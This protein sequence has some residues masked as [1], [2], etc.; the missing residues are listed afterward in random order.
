MR[1]LNSQ[2]IMPTTTS[3]TPEFC[4]ELV[5][6]SNRIDPIRLFLAL[7][8]LFSHSYP[9]TQGTNAMEPMFRLSHGQRTFGQVAVNLFFVL[10][11][12]LIVRSW[13]YSPSM[14]VYFQRRVLRIHPGFAVAMFVSMGLALIASVTPI[15]HL[16]ALPKRQFALSLLTLEY[17]TLNVLNNAFLG[18]P[19][20][21]VNGSLWTIPIEFLAY[22][23]VA[24]YGLFG[25]FRWRSL[26]FALSSFVLAR[27]V[28]KVFAGVD[29]QSAWGFVCYFL[30][31]ISFYLFRDLI[32]RSR[33]WLL[34]ASGLL[35]GSLFIPPW[36]S[37]F[38]PV[39]APYILF[40]LALRPAQAWM[41]WT[42][43]IDLSYGVYLYAFVVQQTLVYWLQV[44]TPLRLALLATPITLLFAAMS[45][46]F[47][48]EPFL[49]L[50]HFTFR[51]H[52]PGMSLPKLI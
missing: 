16:L 5:L 44:R 38:F 33:V 30:S 31:G 3:T 26:W 10:S 43:R 15:H 19:S 9:L 22:I 24:V 23:G 47:V 8:V 41:R 35:I 32:P 1:K 42:K 51:D 39:A 49:R 6:R 48:E 50:K 34:I 21:S 28:Q 20:Q 37:V 14:Q 52:D 18:N 45:W 7:L 36:F 11:G 25:L 17:G 27:Y 46:F 12:F 40:Y 13:L 29:T 2:S 4:S